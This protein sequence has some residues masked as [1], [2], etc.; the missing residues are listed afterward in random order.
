MNRWNKTPEE[1]VEL[2]EKYNIL[3]YVRL[4]YEP[5]H[6]TGDEGIAE[7]IEEFVRNKGGTW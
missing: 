2:D 3:W 5:F 4:S 6:L 1:F 7:Y